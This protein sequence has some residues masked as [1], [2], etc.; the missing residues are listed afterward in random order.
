MIAALLLAA[1]IDTTTASRLATLAI[2]SGV[3]FFLS[4]AFAFS[5]KGAVGCVRASRASSQCPCTE[6]CQS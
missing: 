4:A 3:M 5:A 6:E 1:A 2:D